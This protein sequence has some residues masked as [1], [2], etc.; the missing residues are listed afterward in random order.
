MKHNALAIIGA[1]TLVAMSLGTA[2][3]AGRAVDNPTP[4]HKTS[5]TAEQ[6]GALGGGY[7]YT[8]RPNDNR[9]V[10]R[11][12]TEGDAEFAVMEAGDETDRTPTAYH[13]RPMDNP[14][15]AQ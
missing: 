11:A 15:L 1:G 13:G 12:R 10:Q 7:V 4:V 14:H 8:G 6:G 3:A 5:T 2:Q 9:V